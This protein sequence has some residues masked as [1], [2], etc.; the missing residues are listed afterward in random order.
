MF[1]WSCGGAGHSGHNKQGCIFGGRRG[2][3]AAATAP[4]IYVHAVPVVLLLLWCHSFSAFFFSVQNL[5]VNLF[6]LRLKASQPA[7]TMQTAHFPVADRSIPS[8]WD[9][10]LWSERFFSFLR[11]FSYAIRRSRNLLST[12]FNVMPRQNGKYAFGSVFGND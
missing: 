12:K 1:Q 4:P 8:K 2:R 7:N 5:N 11:S 9:S 6:W 10:C 3:S